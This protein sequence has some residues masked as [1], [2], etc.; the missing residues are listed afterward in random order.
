MKKHLTLMALIISFTVFNASFAMEETEQEILEKAETGNIEAMM[1][2]I[3]KQAD[4]CLTNI[5]RKSCEEA[6]K[7]DTRA[8]LRAKQDLEC[9]TYG[10]DPLIEE[11]ICNFH[12]ASF[13]LSEFVENKF[14]HKSFLSLFTP[15]YNYDEEEKNRRLKAIKSVQKKINNDTLSPPQGIS[16]HSIAFFMKHFG[17][18]V[19][20][21]DHFFSENECE[22]IRQKVLDEF[23]ERLGIPKPETEK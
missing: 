2:I 5:D 18:K 19:V 11:S 23:H 7:W 1:A 14:G 16:H 22:S 6:L 17:L 9:C 10:Y 4:K 15:K 3:V 8:L 13:I 21:I 12:S 20:A